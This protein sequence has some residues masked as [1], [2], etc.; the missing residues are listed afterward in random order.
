[1]VANEGLEKADP[2]PPGPTALHPHP[3]D[4]NSGE[5]PER[6]PLLISRVELSQLLA[7]RESPTAMVGLEPAIF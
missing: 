1:M 7:E 2:G 5:M 6:T 3:K 4:A